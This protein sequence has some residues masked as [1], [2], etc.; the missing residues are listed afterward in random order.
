MHTWHSCGCDNQS[1]AGGFL[2]VLQF[3]HLA[4]Q[5]HTNFNKCHYL[6]H[7]SLSLLL[8]LSLWSRSK[9]FRFVKEDSTESIC[10][11]QIFLCDLIPHENVI[12]W[13]QM[14]VWANPLWICHYLSLSLSLTLSL[15]LICIFLIDIS[16]IILSHSPLY[17]FL[18]NTYHISMITYYIFC[19]SYYHFLLFGSVL[20][21]LKQQLSRR[22]TKPTKWVVRP[23][24]TQINLGIRPVWSVFAVRM[25][26][27]WVVSYPLSAQWRL[28]SDWA[29]AQADLSLR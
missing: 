1:E 9:I 13:T 7:L 27:P 23:A 5:A 14:W 6:Q 11:Y 28:W 26:K 19:Q 8:P 10:I 3:I 21:A 22:T 29:D 18:I 16:V 15:L 4:D 12:I 17:C 2:W 24:K 25:K 20:S